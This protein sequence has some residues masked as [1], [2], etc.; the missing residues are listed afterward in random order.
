[1]LRSLLF[2]LAIAAP[3]LS[4]ADWP[5]FRGPNGA[6]VSTE[7]NLPE[8]LDKKETILWK[9]PLTRGISSPVIVGTTAFLTWSDGQRDD[10]LAVVAIDIANGKTKWTRT[11]TATGLTACHPKTNMAAPTVVADDKAVYALFATADLVAYDHDGNLLW[12]RSL[13]GDYPTIANIVGMASSPVLAKDKLL[14]PMDNSGDSFLAAIDVKTGKNLWKAPRPRESSWTT[15][16]IR[17]ITSS[18]VEVLSQ[19]QKEFAAYDLDT[20]KKK[21]TEKLPSAVPMLTVSEGTFLV[22]SGGVKLMKPTKD[23]K[24]EEVWKSTKLQTGYSTPL[25]Y[26]GYVYAANPAGVLYCADAKTGQ[27]AWEERIK[28][29]K[30]TFSSSP[31]GGDGKVYIATEAGTLCAFKAGK[32]AELIASVEL[33]EECL[34]TPAIANG[35]LFVRT[36]KS[37]ICFGAK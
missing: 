24:L 13:T 19:N 15:P 32:E 4:A 35:R 11:I 34:A 33:G 31:I 30:Q 27:N 36:S 29:A 16:T 7:K 17:E 2:V 3:M 14:V 5:Q 12:C 23:G 22:P 10:R 9:V 26:D 8:A 18:E 28:G 37:L 25:L 1:M 20:G 6:G 21:W